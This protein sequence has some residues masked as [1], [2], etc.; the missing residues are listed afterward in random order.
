[1]SVHRSIHV[2]SDTANSDSNNGVFSCGDSTT[3]SLPQSTLTLAVSADINEKYTVEFCPGGLGSGAN[4]APTTA[5]NMDAG[6]NVNA[7]SS[8]GSW[9]GA[10]ASSQAGDPTTHSTSPS[11][12]P[13][14][15]PDTNVQA[16]VIS[17]APETPVTP[18]V[19][20]TSTSPAAGAAQAPAAE[21]PASTDVVTVTITAATVTAPTVTETFEARAPRRKRRSRHGKRVWGARGSYQTEKSGS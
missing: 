16:A 7:A 8:S 5:V 2:R 12:S 10:T 20:T 21:D 19:D 17:P 13:T 3:V 11:P 15:D 4:N 1:M 9:A 14:N 6:G 18:S